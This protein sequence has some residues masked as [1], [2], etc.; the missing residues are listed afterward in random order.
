M[1]EEQSWTIPDWMSSAM[2][3]A[4]WV[5][6]T[7]KE[8]RIILLIR[9]SHREII[10]DHTAQLSTELTPLGCEMS[11]GFGRRMPPDRLTRVFFSFVSRCYQTAE[12]ITKGLRENGAEIREFDTLAI[13]ATPEI[14]DQSVWHELQPDG[15]NIT[16]FINS[17]ADGRFGDKI[18]PF[19]DYEVRLREDLLERVS[20]DA[21]GAMH[22]HVTHDLALMAAKR[23]FLGRAV[24]WEDREPFLGGL[25]IAIVDGNATLYVGT[26]GKEY[27][28]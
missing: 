6:L 4:N 17:W 20:Q 10:E 25:A 27:S 24:E 18:E 2:N 12:E 13:L 8:S 9:H 19:E 16:D 21:D 14:R 1:D 11:T 3:I 28:L 15:R 26:S 22:I 7:P 23:I 5:S